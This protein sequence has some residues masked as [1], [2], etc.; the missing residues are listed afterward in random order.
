MRPRALR[1]ADR[2]PPLRLCRPSGHRA[3]E[4][5]PLGQPERAAPGVGGGQRG[6]GRAKADSSGSWCADRRVGGKRAASWSARAKSCGA[7]IDRH[8]IVGR[9]DAMR[10][11]LARVDRVCDADVP[12]VIQGE[13]GTGKE[14]VAARHPLRRQP[15]A[16]AL[17]RA[18]TARRSP[19]R[20]SRASC[21]AT[22]A[23]RSP[24]PTATGAACS[25]KASGG[26]LFLDEVGRHAAKMQ[27]DLLRV[28]Q[29][30]KVRPVGGEVEDPVDVR[31]VAASN[32]SLR[33]LVQRGHL[34]R[35][36]LL[37]AERRR[38]L[39]C[40]RCATGPRTSPCSQSTSSPDPREA[41][42]VSP[43]GSAATRSSG[44]PPT[45]CPAT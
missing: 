27:V 24:A 29:D 45:R 35:G 25:S 14:L 11:I 7:A 5:S 40:R 20:C 34:P 3:R 31:V 33:D 22:C 44:W 4:R 26:T 30:R 2:G 28:L 13:S 43:S 19:K 16:A 42:R 36:P 37:P 10:R 38:D 32:K 21:S 1:R 6:L 23:A 9:S 15:R 41:G 12:V 39:R 17:R 8:G 18:S